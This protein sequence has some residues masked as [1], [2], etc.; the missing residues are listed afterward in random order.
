MLEKMFGNSLKETSFRIGN[1]L[2]QKTRMTE[3]KEPPGKLSAEERKEGLFDFVHF[4][5]IV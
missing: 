5:K 4:D 1:P 2:K 3:A